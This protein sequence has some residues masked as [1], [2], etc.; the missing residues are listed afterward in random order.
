[1]DLSFLADVSVWALPVLA[2]IILH[3]VAHGWVAL[4]FGD[5]TARDAGRLTLNPLPHIDP[6]GT[7]ALPL[8]LLLSGAPF[9][10]GYARPVPVHFGRLR[11]PKRDMIFVAAAGPLTNLL[12]AAASAVLVRLVWEAGLP[13]NEQGFA[14]QVALRSV[15]MNVGLAAFNLVP[16]PPLDGG[17][18]LT[19]LLPLRLALVFARVERYGMLLVI[20]FLASGA[21]RTVLSPVVMAL[22]RFLL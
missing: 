21:S 8:L 2:A 6:V 12:L 3:E 16:I 7:V 15:L 4:K 1:M 19:G 9:L 11:N 13:P 10:F 5:P 20:L 22:L 14:A 17:R 18:V